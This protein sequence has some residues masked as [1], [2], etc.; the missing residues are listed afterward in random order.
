MGDMMPPPPA[1]FRPPP[2]PIAAMHP[3]APPDVD[4]KK[5][6]VAPARPYDIP[7]W[8]HAPGKP[9]FLEVLKDGS[10]L[11][12]LPVSEKGAY[13]FGRHENCDFALDHPS[14][15]R[16]HAVLQYNSN[17][18]AFIFDL[19]STHGTFVNKLKVKAKVHVPVHV[20]SIF[21][22]GLST[23]MYLFQ[24]PEELMPQE[25]LSRKDRQI[26]RQLEAQ[27]SKEEEEA[28]LLRAR[29]DAA[30]EQGASWGMGEDAV[31]EEAVEDDLT[32]QSYKGQLTEKQQKTMEQIQ[33]RNDKL[34][35]L[36]KEIDAIQA[37]EAAQGG[38]TQ[39]QQTQVTRNEKRI[40]ELLE[41]LE[42][43]EETL[44]DSIKES[45]FG[46]TGAKRK[47]KNFEGEEEDD[48]SD[49]DFYDRTKKKHK[50]DTEAQ[51]AASLLE[52]LD[53]LAKEMEEVRL[54]LIGEGKKP[55]P[56]G[57]EEGSDDPL[58]AYMSNVSTEL[59]E[60]G[61]TR[62][63]KEL[64]RLQAETDKVSTLLK[65][66]DP[67]GEITKKWKTKGDESSQPSEVP[68]EKSGTTLGA[69]KPDQEAGVIS[70][71]VIWIG[72]PRPQEPAEEPASERAEAA[73][74]DAAAEDKFV[75]Y[76]EWKES[77]QRH[78]PTSL[79]SGGREDAEKVSEDAVANDIALLLRHKKGLTS[80]PEATERE[81]ETAAEAPPTKTKSKKKKA[82][83]KRTLG[84]ERPKFM[85]DEETEFES[86]V[87]P[88]GQTGDGRT[89]LNEKYGY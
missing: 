5:K 84:P 89:L 46:I 41:Q 72:A 14:I 85:A 88:V 36:K 74:E 30:A 77:L 80:S 31:D 75:P 47:T 42:N 33:K 58:D 61:A 3:P 15:S 43:L 24:G 29:A 28:S 66:A 73:E 34:T 16:H 55:M 7:E 63:R 8:S 48:L 62:L 57:H 19:S 32:W 12:E 64:D 21:R 76:K 23:R 20:G 70:D 60:D 53:Q 6:I 26:M 38:L 49:D 50:K 44:N 86:W 37:K 59:V 56:S 17:G 65:V 83:E 71:S 51:S 13:M 87:P 67:T 35:N 11:E 79:L 81:E 4:D 68:P 82:K 52:K 9:Y 2:P 78:N 45:V 54:K 10:I 22:F 25:G 27:Q 18:D 40:E 39:G 69:N 1:V